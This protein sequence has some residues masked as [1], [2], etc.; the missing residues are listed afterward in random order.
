MGLK[1]NEDIWDT[2][3]AR[4]RQQQ[5]E[6]EENTQ[7]GNRVIKSWEH[8]GWGDSILFCNYNKREIAGHLTPL[9]KVGDEFQV[10]MV[11]GKIGRFKIVSVSYCGNP[12]DMFFGI[13]EDIDY[14]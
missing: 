4:Q 12:A 2:F 1:S 6:I 3:E 10:K 14:V 13:V 9:P 8:T 11:S 5:K 7:Q